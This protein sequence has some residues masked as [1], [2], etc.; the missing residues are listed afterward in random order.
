LWLQ[1]HP[2]FP[3]RHR[4]TFHLDTLRIAHTAL[5]VLHSHIVG[6]KVDELQLVALAKF[7]QVI[8]RSIHFQ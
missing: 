1:E 8:L 3:I 2:L 5:A 4:R 7:S 6:S